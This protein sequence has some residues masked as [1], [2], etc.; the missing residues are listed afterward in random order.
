MQQV[1][2]ASQGKVPVLIAILLFLAVGCSRNPQ[3]APGD[4]D[5]IDPQQ[6]NQVGEPVRLDRSKPVP[7]K[8]DTVKAWQKRQDAIKSFRFVW[9]EQQT[10]PKGWLSNPRFPERERSSIPALL[11]DRTYAVSKSLAVDGNKMRYTFELDR[12]AEAD[13]IR[14]K[15]EGDGRSDGLGLR[16]HYSYVS[17][18]DGQTGKTSLT[19]L[20]DS[21]APAI[22]STQTNPDAQ[23]LD[24]RAILLAFRPLD[25]VMGDLS[26]DRAVTNGVRTFYKGRSIFLLE[27]QHDPSGWKMI[28]WVEPERDFLISRCAVFFEQ[29][30]IVDIEIDYA[31]DSQWGWIPN[32]WRITEMLADGTR[33]LVSEAKVSTYTINQ[34]IGSEEFK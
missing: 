16:R 29:K 25:S 11:Y 8:A 34:S 33:R 1:G 6:V 32:G 10:H 24:T 4:A 7:P 22:R 17:V 18:F 13:G 9:I 12:K 20:L 5:L 15:A 31:Q 23:N 27:E 21:P 2:N 19:S 30:F 28:L 3:A 14:V 26:I